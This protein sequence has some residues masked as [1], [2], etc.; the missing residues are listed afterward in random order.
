MGVI[1]ITGIGASTDTDALEHLHETVLEHAVAAIAPEANR[2]G[3]AIYRDGTSLYVGVASA[4]AQLDLEPVVPVAQDGHLRFHATIARAPSELFVM[5]TAG[6]RGVA[7]CTVSG[8][9]PA[10][11][12]DCPFTEGDARAYVE[13]LGRDGDA[14][15]CMPLALSIGIASEGAGLAYDV[16]WPSEAVALDATQ[17]GAA[18]L[19]LLNGERAQLGVPP[20]SLSVAQS[21]ANTTIV[22]YAFSTDATSMEQAMLYAMAGWELEPGPLVREGRTIQID[23]G[24]ATDAGQ[25]LFQALETPFERWVLLDPEARVLALGAASS[26]ESTIGVATTYRF[27]DGDAESDR[28]VAEHALD[29]ARRA[30]G[31]GPASFVQ[32]APLENAAGAI[33]DGS[34]APGPAL[35]NALGRIVETYASARGHVYVASVLDHSPW[36]RDLLEAPHVGIAVRHARPEGSAWG[37]YVV[38]AVALP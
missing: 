12:I 1:P 18:V 23:A 8:I 33:A 25:W 29:E 37:V 28:A 38:L 9:Q 11:E 30:A 6:E 26:N 3:L 31:H 32:L 19:P 10:L 17:L 24:R 2:V 5:T 16:R 22:P 27:F 14:V 34:A 7:E 15:L 13:I 21:A 36:D 20:L 35:D 4:L